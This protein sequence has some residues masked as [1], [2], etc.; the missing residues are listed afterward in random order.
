MTVAA[1]L[2]VSGFAFGIADDALGLLQRAG[3]VT[4][5]AVGLGRRRARLF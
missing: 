2:R 4:S 3:D 1:L 5:M